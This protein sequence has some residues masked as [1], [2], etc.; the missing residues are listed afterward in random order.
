MGLLIPFVVAPLRNY[1]KSL[2]TERNGDTKDYAVW[3]ITGENVLHGRDIYYR[4]ADGTFEF[5]YPPTTATLLAIPSAL[6]KLPMMVALIALNTAAW[7]V[8]IFLSVYLATGS[9]WR[10]H[11]L[12]YLVPSLLTA[13]F[14]WSTYLLGQVN[15][16]L[17]AL[18]LCGL[19]ALR[20]K[21]WLAG[22]CFALATCIKAFP[23]LIVL[24]LAYRRCWGAIL[25]LGVWMLVLLLVLPMP[26][27][28]LSQPVR[29]LK[30]WC[31]GMLF[32]N[33]DQGI[34]Q[35]PQR[36][37]SWKNQSLLATVTRLLRAV[38]ADY[39]MVKDEVGTAPATESA[40]SEHRVDRFVNIVDLPPK[41]VLGI[42]ALAGLG[43][44]VFFM[45]VTWRL[46]RPFVMGR[47]PTG[48]EA[49]LVILLILMLSPYSFG[50]FYTWLLFP[51][52]VA[53]QL[54]VAARGA[55]TRQRFAA[56]LGIFMLLLAL[57][58]PIR[59]LR[60]VKE[61]GTTCIACLMLTAALG[62]QLREES[63]PDGTNNT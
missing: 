51:F 15:L 43:C 25:W 14:I 32:N 10:Q 12:V 20:R 55:A 13:P 61:I 62:L 54:I 3:F 4:Q 58:L 26:F 29:D 33:S 40:T 57:G 19:A 38:P 36:T 44:M 60:G 59:A 34:G 35:R 45:F 11:P 28:G 5:M 18:M 22:F 39:D 46:P 52:T 27:R 50:Y 23:F 37:Y 63:R 8:A 2:N 42:A 7:V 30:T 1:R 56:V 53:M 24:Y 48:I 49:A 9:P 21:A 17:L 16:L 31:E 41:V 47:E 6:G